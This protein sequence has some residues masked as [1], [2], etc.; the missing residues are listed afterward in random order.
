MSKVGTIAQNHTFS[1]GCFDG[2][3]YGSDFTCSE[4]EPTTFTHEDLRVTMEAHNADL[5]AAHSEIRGLKLK[6]ALAKKTKTKTKEPKEPKKPKEPK[7]SPKRS[8]PKKSPKK[9]EEGP[10]LAEKQYDPDFC[11]ARFWNGG[12]G[13]QCWREL[14]D[15]CDD[16]CKACGNRRDDPNKDY[17]GC[18]D[19]PVG[20]DSEHKKN[21]KPHAWKALKAVKVKVVK[22]VKAVEPVVETPEE[23]VVETPEEPVVETPEEPVEEPDQKT[24]YTCYQEEIYVDGYHLTWNKTTNKLID[25]DDDMVMG[26]MVEKDGVW[27]HKIYDCDDSDDSDDEN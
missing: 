11:R 16:H 19:E 13:G 4:I 12:H 10:H 26:D 23:P 21:G 6:L 1:Q 3:L 7:A 2:D 24:V 27:T 17:W 14:S 20:S 18:F 5:A 8:P 9:P 15:R 22:A 25:P